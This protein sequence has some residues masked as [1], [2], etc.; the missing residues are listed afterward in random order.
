MWKSVNECTRVGELI[1]P[2]QVSYFMKLEAVCK[3]NDW[4]L[5]HSH[6]TIYFTLWW[7]NTATTN[8]INAAWLHVIKYTQYYTTC[9]FTFLCTCIFILWIF[10]QVDVHK[11]T[12]AYVIVHQRTTTLAEK[13]VTRQEFAEKWKIRKM[14]GF[15]GIS[16]SHLFTDSSWIGYTFCA[17]AE[18]SQKS[19][20]HHH[21]NHFSNS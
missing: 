21:N 1:F 15:I 10:K 12:T 2:A 4:L 3:I 8:I 19:H 9:V 11:V 16:L 13:L 6:L 18:R 7:I 17:K 20:R 14:T 5:M